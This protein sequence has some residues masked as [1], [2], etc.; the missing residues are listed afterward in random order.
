MFKLILTFLITIVPTSLINVNNSI[1][2]YDSFMSEI[3]RTYSEYVI[4]TNDD[5]ELYH[6]TIIKGIYNSKAAYGICFSSVEE[7]KYHITL[8]DGSIAYSFSENFIVPYDMAIAIDGTYYMSINIID[9]N[10][11]QEK[12]LELTPFTIK[13]FQNTDNIIKGDNEGIIFDSLYIYR[14]TNDFLKV[15]LI[16]SVSVIILCGLI[17]LIMYI[18]QSGM[19]NKDNRQENVIN[20]RKL[21][22]EDTQDHV[23]TND[24]YQ[25]EEPKEQ[26]EDIIDIKAYLKE[27]GFL[28]NYSNLSEED[29]NK[30]MLELIKLKNEKRISLDKYYEETSELWKN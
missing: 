24:Y 17:I 4:D 12:L 9:D 3:D 29:K 25:K 5:N 11:N 21:L 13:S 7:G 18:K 10:K 23:S 1:N 15:L 20:I 19:F 22:K 26:K 27:K 28:T 14:Q 6:L 30:I 16:V 2:I 8:S